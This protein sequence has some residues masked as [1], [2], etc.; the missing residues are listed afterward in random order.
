ME[1]PKWIRLTE[2]SDRFEAEMLKAA[3]EAQGIPAAIFQEG[4][5][6]A[7]YPA[8]LMAVAEICVP[9]SHIEQALAWLEAY[10]NG[11]FEDANFDETD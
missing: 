6:N 3:L 9:S 7:A 10:E 8:G 11:E 4:V 2:A 5:A 1:Q